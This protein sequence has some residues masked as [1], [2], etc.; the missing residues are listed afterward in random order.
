MNL[1]IKREKDPEIFNKEITYMMQRM[2]INYI[3]YFSVQ[4]AFMFLF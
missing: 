2:K 3:V 4:G 1:R